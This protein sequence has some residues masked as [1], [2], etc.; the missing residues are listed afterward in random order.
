M[1]QSSPQCQALLQDA[2]ALQQQGDLAGAEA[3]YLQ[4]LAQ[5]A[6]HLAALANLGLISI[7][8]GQWSQAEAYLRQALAVEP[9]SA[10]LYYQLGF[11]CHQQGRLQ[12][13]GP[14]YQQAIR[15]HPEF[16]EAYAKLGVVFKDLGELTQAI[17]CYER[18]LSL[19]PQAAD[20]WSNLG[21]ALLEHGNLSEAADACQ[22]ALA[23]NP[24]L[25]AAHVNL[26]CV[27]HAQGRLE[28]AASAYQAA[29][30]LQP[31]V[32]LT[33]H[34]LGLVWHGLGRLDEAIACHQRAID[35]CPD[36]AEAHFSLAS[37]QLLA[38]N[39]ASG[40]Q[41]YEWRFLAK[42]GTYSTPEG[43]TRWTGPLPT[44]PVTDCDELIVVEEQG[45]GD[46]L[47]FMRYAELLKSRFPQVSLAV[48][49]PLC[50]LIELTGLFDRVYPLPIRRGDIRP[51]ARW[52]YILSLP[53][54][55]GVTRENPR[56]TEPYIRI[57]P[58]RAEV[59]RGKIHRSGMLTVG[60]NWQ[61]DPTSE[62][63]EFRGRSFSLAALAPLAE[64]PGVQF[65]SLQKG[66]GA[67]QLAQCLFRDRFVSCQDEI[68]DA[69]DFVDTAAIVAQCDL[70]ITSDTSIAH[71]AGGLGR[72]TWIL[73][74]KIPDWR[75]GLTGEDP[76]W[77]PS[78][79]LFRQSQAGDWPEVIG[80]V[81]AELRK[82]VSI[83]QPQ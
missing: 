71:L 19:N 23:M 32:A 83:G 20:T 44:Q 10:A 21:F 58:D 6:T 68:S 14:L 34:N 50:R 36:Y 74:K 2:L 57:P 49:E 69:W 63:T 17:A 28:E 79:R 54:L 8:T 18:A 5:E 48:R 26:G 41:E 55:L 25:P 76:P 43:L 40:W 27:L 46:V 12:E 53:G 59:W 39:Y 52:L 1:S 61:G 47:Q 72:P 65:V 35:L 4:L 31:D 29:L 75:W 78:A 38:G 56:I 11:A 66:F 81:Q 70:V 3:N 9:A 67:E 24:Q 30:A 42:P 7:L 22:R 82:L 62:H 45:I 33:H 37:V 15:L 13:A 77:Y 51:H 73:L 64:I 60:L 16:A 80:R